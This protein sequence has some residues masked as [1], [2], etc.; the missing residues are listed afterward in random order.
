MDFE[1][2]PDQW[3]EIAKTNPI[4]LVIFCGL[5]G[6]SAVAQFVKMGFLAY[7]DTTKITMTRYR[8]SMYVLALLFTT[9]ITRILWEQVIPPHRSG[10]GNTA[11]VVTGFVSPYAYRFIK[12]AISTWKPTF[13]EKWGDNGAVKWKARP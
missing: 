13:A 12:A 5:L 2:H 4:L 11:S 9:I 10:L 3:L 7:G 6:G 8:F 1:F